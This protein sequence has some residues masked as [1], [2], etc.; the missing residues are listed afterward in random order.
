MVDSSVAAMRRPCALLMACNGFLGLHVSM[1][2]IGLTRDRCAP[3]LA[4]SAEGIL[5]AIERYA[6]PNNCNERLLP[7]VRKA[8]LFLT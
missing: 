3:S 6:I 5:E 4:Q 7:M 1:V 8:A 2:S